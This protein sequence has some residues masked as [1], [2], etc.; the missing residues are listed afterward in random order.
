MIS[1][2]LFWLPVCL[3]LSV[4]KLFTFSS[5]SAKLLGWFQPNLGESIFGWR[6]FNFVEMKVQ[7]LFLRGDDY[8][9]V[10]IHN[11]NSQISSTTSVPVST[12]FDTKHPW[13]IGIQDFQGEIMMKYQKHIDEIWNLLQNHWV[14]FDQ[15]W[16]KAFLDEGDSSLFNW[17]ATNSFTKGEIIMKY[18][19]YIDKIWKS[20]SPKP[21]GKFQLFWAQSTLK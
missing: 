13:V 8:K 20:F 9:I 1:G 4:C 14:N 17:R 10:K 15:T 5:S 6:W 11:Q 18:Q 2:E 12:R 16:H 21:L 3:S 19:K 7:A